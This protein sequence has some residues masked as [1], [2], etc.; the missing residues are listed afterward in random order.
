MSFG[1]I[2]PFVQSL[3]AAPTLQGIPVLFGEEF[4]ED[5]SQNPPLIV[6]VPLGGPFKQGQA[7]MKNPPANCTRIWGVTDQI[8]VWCWGF[9]PAE[10]AINL[11]H[12]D[13]T[14]TLAA[15]VLQAL[16]SQRP[17]GLMYQPVR[18]QWLTD[19]KSF[20]RYGRALVLTFTADIAIPGVTPPTATVTSTDITATIST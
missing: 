11:D 1:S 5:E 3:Q 12:V 16:D 20:A 2:K 10:G 19:D 8:E 14:E 15:Q 13:A 4:E 9:D 18:R 17:S 6:V 7:Y